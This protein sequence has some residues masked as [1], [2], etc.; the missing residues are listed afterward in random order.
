MYPRAVPRLQTRLGVQS[1]DSCE[2][3][4]TMD[5]NL[6]TRIVSE[7]LVQLWLV[8]AYIV[9][10]NVIDQLSAMTDIDE[11]VLDYVAMIDLPLLMNVSK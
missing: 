4:I 8:H 7:H 2:Y 3:N 1:F 10:Q 11:I 5:T 9:A 6:T